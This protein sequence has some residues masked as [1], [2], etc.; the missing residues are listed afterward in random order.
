ML[1]SDYL[2][3]LKE[4]KVNRVPVCPGVYKNLILR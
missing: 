3:P 2:K 4:K 1:E